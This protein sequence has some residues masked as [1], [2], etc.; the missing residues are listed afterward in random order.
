MSDGRRTCG[1]K[2]MGNIIKYEIY[3]KRTEHGQEQE[4]EGS[5]YVWWCDLIPKSK[6]HGSF[7]KP[8]QFRVV[9]KVH[10]LGGVP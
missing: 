10:F 8:L 9:S 4:R 7:I 1:Q 3:M 6:L 5:E 2:K